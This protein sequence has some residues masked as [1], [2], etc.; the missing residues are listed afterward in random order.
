MSLW[1]TKRPTIHTNAPRHWPAIEPA[2][3][4]GPAGLLM[5][6]ADLASLH[7]PPASSVAFL[8]DF[9]YVDGILRVPIVVEEG[10]QKTCVFVYTNRDE[11]A[12]AHFSGVRALLRSREGAAAVYYSQ[13]AITPV[14][15]GDV[16]QPID[17]HFFSKAAGRDASF[18]L[19]WG[20][21][22]A[23]KLAGS[24]ET[25]FLDRWFE[26][27][28]GYGFLLLTAFLKDLDLVEDKKA[29]YALPSQPLLQPVTGPGETGMLLYASAGEGFFLAFDEATPVARRRVVLRLLADF[30]VQFRRAI[31]AKG[32]PPAG[33]EKGLGL[34]HWRAIRDEALAKEAADGTGVKLHAVTVRDGQPVRNLGATTA[35]D[36]AKTSPDTG[37]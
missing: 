30:A 10:A 17:T 35:Q 12:A 26:A 7:K 11:N 1:G 8:R 20:T 5:I 37:P 24:E 27:M 4:A 13:E 22:E 25:V 32:P 3:L 34:A 2:E 6:G 15:P 21:D 28:D 18:A 19:W 36:R 9:L 14:K 33:N 23:P 31:D 29:V 16:L